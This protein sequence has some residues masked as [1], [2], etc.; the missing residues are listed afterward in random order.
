MS[1]TT[2]KSSVYTLPRFFQ[3]FGQ[4]LIVF[5]AEF[6]KSLP[7]FWTTQGMNVLFISWSDN[8]AKRKII[9]A[10]RNTEILANMCRSGV[11]IVLEKLGYFDEI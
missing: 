3:K 8:V 10:A 6:D 1:C 2:L 5:E 9:I 11:P 7:G 4:V